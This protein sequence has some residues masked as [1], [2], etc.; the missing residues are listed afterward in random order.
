MNLEANDERDGSH[1]EAPRNRKGM[2]PCW[3]RRQGSSV[4]AITPAVQVTA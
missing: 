2:L 3:C 1:T 4:T